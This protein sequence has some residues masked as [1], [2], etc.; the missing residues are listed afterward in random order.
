MILKTIGTVFNKF[1]NHNIHWKQLTKSQHAQLG[2][3]SGVKA[4]S[5]P[6]T[7]EVPGSIPG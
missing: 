2:G 5:T 6:V 3:Q 1:D 4:T 7:S